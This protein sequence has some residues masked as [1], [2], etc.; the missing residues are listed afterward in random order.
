MTIRP[1][2]FEPLTES[3]NNSIPV[4]QVQVPRSSTR[5]SQFV[6]AQVSESK[7]PELGSAKVVISGGRALKSKENFEMVYAL[8]DAFGPGVAAVGASRA[9][10]D[11]GMAPNDLQVKN[12]Q[13]LSNSR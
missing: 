12:E 1:S 5:M 8:A 13:C 6:K 11:A 7:R 2:C 9:A 10:V 3:F 4:E